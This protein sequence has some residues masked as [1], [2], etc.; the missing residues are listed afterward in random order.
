LPIV[1]LGAGQTVGMLKVRLS[2]GSPLQVNRQITQDSEK[3]RQRVNMV[4]AQERNK[5]ERMA[6]KTISKNVAA[7]SGG[8]F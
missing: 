7:G 1:S 4:I 3:E 5:I 6:M 2:M 8:G